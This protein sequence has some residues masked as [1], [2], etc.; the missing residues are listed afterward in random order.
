MSSER[1]RSVMLVMPALL[2]VILYS[3]F[4][5]RPLMAS[6]RAKESDAAKAASSAVSPDAV[7]VAVQQRDRL[8]A[9]VRDL[10][11]KLDS[12]AVQTSSADRPG[13]RLS[14]SEAALE[15]TRLFKTHR[16]VIEASEVANSAEAAELV[17]SPLVTTVEKLRGRPQFREPVLYRVRFLGRYTDVLAL[18]K[19]LN[20]ESVALPLHLQMEE[21]RPETAWRSWTLFA[22]L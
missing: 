18:I 14:A 20:E 15:L 3:W 11:A 21:A 13:S 7:P 2:V 10:K 12:H 9:D 6:L 5:F 16:L 1:E 4:W 22:W 19:Q 8:Q 17:P